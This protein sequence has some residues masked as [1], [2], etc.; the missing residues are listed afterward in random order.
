MKSKKSQWKVNQDKAKAMTQK[1]IAVLKNLDCYDKWYSIMVESVIT[2]MVKDDEGD[3]GIADLM[4]INF[5][6]KTFKSD[7]LITD[8]KIENFLNEIKENPYQL[9]LIA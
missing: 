7:S 2:E 9:R 8:I 3:E 4:E 5:G 6:F 1:F